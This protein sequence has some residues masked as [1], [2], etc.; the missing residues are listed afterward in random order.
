MGLVRVLC[1]GYEVVYEADE[2]YAA[3]ERGRIHPVAPVA[4]IGL[5]EPVRALQEYLHER[6][7]DHN[8]R[9]KPRGYGKEP[10]VGPAGEK[11]Y[12]ASYAGGKPCEDGKPDGD[13]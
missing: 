5:N 9:R 1:D 4:A 6:D 11:G 12:G 8:A 2:D 7:I 10:V 3:E 13:P